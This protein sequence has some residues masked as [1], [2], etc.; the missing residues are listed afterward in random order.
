MFEFSFLFDKLYLNISFRINYIKIII[1]FFFFN[2]FNLIINK[3]K[4]SVI[5]AFT[6]K[7][8]TRIGKDESGKTNQAG[9]IGKDES[10]NT[11]RAGRI[12]KDESGRDESACNLL[13]LL[14]Q[15]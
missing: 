1:I 13:Y 10:G 9:R 6:I 2:H 4:Y 7:P 12:G 8:Q 15:R 11:N 3:D 5:K 14:F